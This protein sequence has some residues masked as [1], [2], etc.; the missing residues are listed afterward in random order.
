MVESLTAQAKFR[1]PRELS[2]TEK[3]VVVLYYHEGLTFAEIGEVLDIPGAK[4]YQIYL[5]TLFKARRLL[6]E[7]K[8]SG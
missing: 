6:R 7:G 5:G 8:S 3:L 1:I 2:E 4:A